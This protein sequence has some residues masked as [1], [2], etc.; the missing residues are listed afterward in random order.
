MIYSPHI[1]WK[2]MDL[3]GFDTTGYCISRTAYPWLKN[4]S[5]IYH[6]ECNDKLKESPPRPS[7][8]VMCYSY[9]PQPSEE[10]RRLSWLL[11][12]QVRRVR[13]ISSGRLPDEL[14][15]IIA[16][17]CIRDCA[18]DI[19]KTFCRDN[20]AYGFQISLSK[21][22]WAR[23]ASLDGVAYIISLAN[24]PAWDDAVLLLQPDPDAIQKMVYVACD[25]LG[26]KD[27][28]F[29]NSMDK[30]RS[31]TQETPGVWWETVLVQG[32]E[33]FGDTDGSKLRRL[34]CPITGNENPV[35]L[36]PVPQ[37]HPERV[38]LQPFNTWSSLNSVGALRM[39]SVRLDKEVTGL[40][41]CWDSRK[42]AGLRA[43]TAGEDLEF[44]KRDTPEDAVWIYFPLRPGETIREIWF[45]DP[46]QDPGIGHGFLVVTDQDRVF[47][48]GPH[49][50]R[51]GGDEFRSSLVYT[52]KLGDCSLFIDNTFGNALAVASVASKPLESS[53]EIPSYPN[54]LWPAVDHWLDFVHT[55][56]SLENVAFVRLCKPKMSEPSI[57]GMLFEYTDGHQESVGQVRFD[58]LRD[59]IVIG[60]IPKAGFRILWFNDYFWPRLLDPECRR[61]SDESVPD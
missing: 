42:I 51:G 16:K 48:M 49:K 14:C 12:H 56:A 11:S 20:K 13:W 55:T 60:A 18:V 15:E 17:Y 4:S 53:A 31:R 23:Y 28:C 27:V 21:P 10:A 32:R 59:R 2:F 3:S 61:D 6:V 29:A 26:V 34:F 40:S 22:I 45:R 43:H 38:Q 54:P 24:E 57:T 41:I 50:Q 5:G 8:E 52:D 33:L 47:L 19:N 35:V 39:T 25:H 58:W 9:R 30:A 44:Y 36:W 46:F 37:P 7:P 1:G